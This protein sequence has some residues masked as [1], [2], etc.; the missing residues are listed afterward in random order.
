MDKKLTA[1]RWQDSQ[2]NELWFWQ[3]QLH[4]GNPDQFHRNIYYQGNMENKCDMIQRFLNTNDL[5]KKVVLDLGSGPEGFC[6]AIPG[7]IK[8]AVDPLMTKFRMMG[9][10][11]DANNVLPVN[12]KAEELSTLF[13]NSIDVIFCMNSIDHH[14]NPE[15]VIE[16]IFDALKPYGH[17][18]ILT[19]LRPVEL[20]DAYHK[21]PLNRED[22]DRWTWRF[23][24]IESQEFPHGPGNPLVQ[25]I[26]HLQKI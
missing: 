8:V 26:M 3:T 2:K 24:K 1:E 13:F 17:A 14:Q 10:K 25:Y 16:N 20:L 15:L 19:D 6:H 7:K 23:E 18:F 4:Q 21:L 5:S 12:A 9:F 11:V 22:L